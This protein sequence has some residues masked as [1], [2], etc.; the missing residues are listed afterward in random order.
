MVLIGCGATAT[1]PAAVST[2]PTSPEVSQPITLG[3]ID[4]EDPTK[5][6]KRFKPLADYLAQ[7]LAEFGISRDQVVIARDIDEMA[8]FLRDGTVDVLF[9]SAFPT[10]AVQEL[11]G[12]QPILRRWKD[13]DPEYWSVYVAMRGD[14]VASVEDLTGKVIALEEP[15]S[16]S[17][18]V[19]PAG[20]LIQ[21]GFRLR[22]VDG[23]GAR[24]GPDEIGYFFTF[25][26]QDT[27][28][29]M[30]RGLV[31]AGGISN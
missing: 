18:F 11:S 12:S 25:D 3:D 2:V 20:T 19:L 26:E 13:S 4:P 21:R 17:G 15:H 1:A 29:L 5:K 10:L 23:P 7:H 28:A 27:I 9:D 8:R 30:M 16:T 14:G 24:V 31:A 22:E 6:L